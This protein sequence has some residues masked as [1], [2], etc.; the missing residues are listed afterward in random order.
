[1]VL[2]AASVILAFFAALS[3]SVLEIVSK[4]HQEIKPLQ[5]NQVDVGTGRLLL[6]GFFLF[7]FP[8]TALVLVTNGL[9][10]IYGNI[11][12]CTLTARYISFGTPDTIVRQSITEVV[13]RTLP[14]VVY[15]CVSGQISVWLISIFGATESISQLGALGRI[16]IAFGIFNSIFT[17]LIVPR[18]ARMAENSS[19]L[20]NRFL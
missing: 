6:N 19:Q 20:L 16:L 13:W 9:P 2:F 8:H 15:H 5:R 7:A 1:M 3:D 4:L 18:I 11:K 10:R 17:T 12:L 14:I